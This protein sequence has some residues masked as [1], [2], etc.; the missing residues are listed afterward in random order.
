MDGVPPAEKAESAPKVESEKPP[1]RR[2]RKPFKT[3]NEKVVEHPTARNPVVPEFEPVKKTLSREKRVLVSMEEERQV[4]RLVDRIGENLGTS[5]K[6]SHLLRASMS[7]LCH[8]EGEIVNA[9]L[10]LGP[11]VRP[12]NGDAIALA[13][14]EFDL[15]KLLSK[16][17]RDAPPLRA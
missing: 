13:Q 1:A 14:F 9:A 15:A 8:A 5:L 7:L 4:E 11:F 10:A 16:A 2:N 3:E 6:L 17:L 12:A